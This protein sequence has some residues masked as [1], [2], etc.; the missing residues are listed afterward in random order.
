[1]KG[2]AFLAGIWFDLKDVRDVFPFREFAFRSPMIAG[3]RGSVQLF[4]NATRLQEIL[5][6]LPRLFCVGRS[7]ER[8]GGG[9]WRFR[10]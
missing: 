3:S 7:N 1:M 5:Q 9:S 4:Q 10:A 2:S 6:M 8:R